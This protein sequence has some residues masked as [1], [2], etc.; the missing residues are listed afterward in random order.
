MKKPLALWAISG[1]DFVKYLSQLQNS[2]AC[3]IA[4]LRSVALKPLRLSSQDHLKSSIFHCRGVLQPAYFIFLLL[5]ASVGFA[6]P[7]GNPSDP[8]ILEEGIWIPDRCWSSVRAGMS[9]DFMLLK[10]LQ[11]CRVSKG[12]GISRPEM[13]W[14]LA[15]SDLGW[16]IRERFDLHF[17][18]GP[19][20]SVQF[21]WHQGGQEYTANSSQG[22]FWGASSKVVLL[23]VQDTTVGVDFH[24]GGIEW[25]QGPFMQNAGPDAQDFTSRLYFWQIAA[26]VS[27]NAGMFRP[28]AG[29]AM[30]QLT[31]IFHP[32]ETKRLRF[33]DLLKVGMYEGCTVTLGSKV[34]LNI[35]ARQIFESGLTVAGEL[36]F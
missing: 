35:E 14:K 34:Y 19:V 26:G 33:H 20:A 1:S 36:R 27:Q 4:L 13:K 15:V 3:K 5:G 30:N 16:N 12:L 11:P 28:Y 23:E 8:S 24:G 17:L 21:Q 32:S 25:M 31:C 9:G 2:S 7:I 29:A 22:L 18:A 10:R 6:A